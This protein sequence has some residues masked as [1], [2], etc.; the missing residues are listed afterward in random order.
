MGRKSE[1][2]EAAPLFFEGTLRPAVDLVLPLS[3]AKAAHERLE[4]G[5][6]FGKIVLTV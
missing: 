2:L 1:L 3:D 5:Q 6:Q 4:T